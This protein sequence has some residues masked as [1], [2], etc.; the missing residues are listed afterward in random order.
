MSTSRYV[1][2]ASGVAVL[3]LF[4][5]SCGGGSSST[6]SSATADTSVSDSTTPDDAGGS[7][8]NDPNATMTVGLD[9]EPSSLDPAGDSLSLANGSVYDGVFEA[10]MA[11]DYV[12]APTPWLAKTVTES[13][14]RLSWTLVVQDGVTFHDGTPFDAAAVKFNLER[15]RVSPYNGSGLKNITA[16]DVVDSMTI[17]ITLAVAWTAF[18][19]VLSGINGVMVSPTSAADPEK[20]K[21]N[22]VGT[23][24]F[25]FTEWVPSDHIL[26]TRN[27]AYWGENK[28]QI[29]SIT[30]KF[31]T[32][33][34]ARLTALIAGDL[35]AMTTIISA[36]V[37]EADSKGFQISIPPVSGYG[38]IHLNN[39]KPGL[40]DARV[41]R[42]L[43]MSIDR[44][45]LAEAFDYFGYD[46]ESGTPIS[47]TSR[48]YAAPA[49][50]NK[51]DPEGAKALLAEYGK[52]VKFTVELLQG[53]QSTVDALAAIVEYWKQVGVVATVKMV[54][55]LTTYVV[56]TITGK[57]DAVGWL[58]GEFSDPD[59]SM[60]AIMH[61][62]GPSNYSVFS[63]PDMDATLDEGRSA[64]DEATRMAAYAKAQDLF[65][66]QMPF[67]V[68]THG[69]VR[70]L[71][72]QDVTGLTQAAFFPS[73]T[74]GKKAK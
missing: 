13:A 58:A 52:P 66:S 7:V 40:D 18:P 43:E 32:D 49:T 47:M 60:F 70:I 14:D 1:K 3:T 37:K 21:R 56:D 28:A 20:V 45:A 42:A 54:P 10:L 24:P 27:D 55:D 8:D 41:R 16:V 69:Q 12:K 4:V 62:G 38:L 29:A 63:N 31:V 34:T 30:Y 39:K 6:D 33:E 71:A 67:I 19:T 5:A 73:R 11:G 44:D 61:T 74:A 50:A 15:Q 36:S 59:G 23:G 64:P 17:K 2:V 57:Y 35:D 25:T 9:T 68:L 26:L 46:I 53:S 72:T 65:R 48:W 51:F 22:P